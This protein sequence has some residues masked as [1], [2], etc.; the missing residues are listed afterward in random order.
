MLSA[1][2]FAWLGAALA[3]FLAGSACLRGYVDNRQIPVLIGGLALYTIG[4]LIM[5][6][7]MRESGMAVAMS[8]SAVV[9]LLMATLIA[10]VIFGERPSA[11]QFAGVALGAVAIGLILWPARQSG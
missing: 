6:R 3:T 9:Q 5:V 7:L 11:T 8:L 10:V 1:A 4:N 2:W